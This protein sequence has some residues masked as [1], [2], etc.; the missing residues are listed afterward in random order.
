MVKTNPVK[1]PKERALL[2]GVKLPGSTMEKEREY[3]DELGALAR[4][5]GAEVAGSVIQQRTRLSG[6]TYVGAG[7]L[8]AIAREV[9][10]KR[11]NLVI[12]DDALSP[13]Q[14][15]NIEKA[16]KVNVIDRTELIL[17][18]FSKRARTKQAKIQVEIAQLTY[19]LPRLRRLWDHL[20]RQEGG[21]G[22]R[23]PGEKQLEVDRRRV[24]ER[25]TRL[26]SELK[27]ITRGTLERR[28]RRGEFF[29]ATLVG[30]TNAGKS[31]LLNSMS[32]SGV[33]ESGRLFSTL[34]STTRRVEMEGG[35]T[36]LFTDTVGFIRK[37]PPNLVAS[38]K[39]TLIDVERA[40]LLLHVADASAADFRE[41]IEVV[42][43]ILE[44]IF[45]GAGT[46]SGDHGA[47]EEVETWLVLNKIDRLSGE[48]VSR[49]EKDFPEASLISASRGDGMEDLRER[50]ADHLKRERVLVRIEVPLSS[51]KA[52]ASVEEAGEVRERRVKGESLVITAA[53][54]RKALSALE[55]MAGLNLI[56]LPDEGGRP[57]KRHHQT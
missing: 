7:K 27:K 56:I 49:L 21:I 34:D 35:G 40:D 16:L 51:G 1:N 39:S 12:F 25:I 5:A 8:E 50:I 43:G 10:E 4:S 14:A 37:L 47:E 11:V 48:G 6:S 24:R 41:E 36:I 53:V 57:E 42:N 18:I 38:F 52:I 32:G 26:K 3:L 2:V 17:D 22:T 45:R 13:A 31:T 29:N 55:E 9:K 46:V 54:T 28:K 33:Y 19:A 30:Y 20:S 15:R 44:G 23:G